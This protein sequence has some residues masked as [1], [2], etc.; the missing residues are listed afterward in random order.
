MDG[1]RLY[2][3]NESFQRTNDPLEY[4]EKRRGAKYDQ[5]LAEVLTAE[6]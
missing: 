4:R 2:T 3:H 5:Q 6:K 1:G